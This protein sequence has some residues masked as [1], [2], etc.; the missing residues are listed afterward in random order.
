MTKAALKKESW[1]LMDVR[2]QLGTGLG[3]SFVIIGEGLAA[4]CPI[5]GPLCKGHDYFV[6]QKK[7]VLDNF[8]VQIEIKTKKSWK[9]L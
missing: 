1:V 4:F 3:F 7:Y 6:W 2:S 9:F 5:L 8:V